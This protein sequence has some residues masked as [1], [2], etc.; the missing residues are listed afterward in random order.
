MLIKILKTVLMALGALSAFSLG[1]LGYA[2]L[3]R[4]EEMADRYEKTGRKIKYS[5]NNRS[6]PGLPTFR[7][8]NN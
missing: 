1:V 3:T 8:S 6:S 2:K 4:N 5:I 7:N